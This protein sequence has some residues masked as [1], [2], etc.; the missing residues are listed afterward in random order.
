MT[1][2]EGTLDPPPRLIDPQERE[3]GRQVHATPGRVD[4]A[5]DLWMAG[6]SP[7]FVADQ[8]GTRVDVIYRW[9]KMASAQ[10][11]I[12]DIRRL[13][14]ERTVNIAV[15]SSTTWLGTLLELSRTQDASGIPI[16]HRDRIA[17]AKSGL[18]TVRRMFGDGVVTLDPPIDETVDDDEL[19]AQVHRIAGRLSSQNI[20][21]AEAS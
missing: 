14:M 1:N 11:R 7:R 5:V 10:K 6:A 17:A 18:E 21:D 19:L 20:I 15:S 16:A 2:L 13:T 9:L 4:R 12:D 3:H 8:L